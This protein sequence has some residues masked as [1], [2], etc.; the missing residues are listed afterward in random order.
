MGITRREVWLWERRKRDT[1]TA[2][3]WLMP[4]RIGGEVAFVHTLI[5]VHGVLE[6]SRTA[7]QFASAVGG[8]RRVK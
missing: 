1:A 7:W 5:A 4:L 8:R 2:R 3:H 6:L